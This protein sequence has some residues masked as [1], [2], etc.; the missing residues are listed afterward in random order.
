M[1]IIPAQGEFGKWHP[2]WGRE[3]LKAFFTVHGTGS[4]LKNKALKCFKCFI[5]LKWRQFLEMFVKRLLYVNNRIPAFLVLSCFS[6]VL[7][8]NMLFQTT[9]IFISDVH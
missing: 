5:C 3:Y 8:N 4:I 6:K 7:F 9:S 1:L 2:G